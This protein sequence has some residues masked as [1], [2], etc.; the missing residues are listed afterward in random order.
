MT[1]AESVCFDFGVVFGTGR[2]RS[3]NW[4]STSSPSDWI[5]PDASSVLGKAYASAAHFGTPMRSAPYRVWYCSTKPQSFDR[6]AIHCDQ[7][8]CRAISKS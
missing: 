5:E 6:Y 8:L 7:K 2:E 4:Q 1:K 3:A